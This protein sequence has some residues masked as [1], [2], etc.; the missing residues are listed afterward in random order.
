MVNVDRISNLPDS[1]LGYIL[2]FLSTKEAVA[3]SIPSSKWR[4]LFVLVSN[5]DFELDESSQMLKISTIESF[6]CF[7]DRV[8]FF[9]NTVNINAFR[10]RCGKRVDSDRVYGWISAAIWRGVKH[11]GLS[12]SL[13][14]FTLPGVLCLKG[15]ND[16]S[17]V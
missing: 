16:S 6:M 7:V 1:I 10:L 12:I 5:L 2:S 4:Y 9:H 15:G 14:N 3:T 17:K 8:L 11:L 13:D